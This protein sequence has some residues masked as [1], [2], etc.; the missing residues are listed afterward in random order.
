MPALHSN[1][2]VEPSKSLISILFALLDQKSIRRRRY[3]GTIYLTDLR[4]PGSKTWTLAS[5]TSDHGQYNGSIPALHQNAFVEQRNSLSSDDPCCWTAESIHR[6]RQ[7]C[8]I[9]LADARR[10]SSETRTL[11]TFTFNPIKKKLKFLV[12]PE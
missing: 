1:A 9:S 11:A 10:P 7:V 6:R 12:S 8:I 3:F 4:R 2:L 5:P